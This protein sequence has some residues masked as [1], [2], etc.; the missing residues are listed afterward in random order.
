VCLF[1]QIIIVNQATRALFKSENLYFLFDPHSN[2]ID[3][4]A[5]ICRANSIEKI[6]DLL[7][8]LIGNSYLETFFDMDFMQIN[9]IKNFDSKLIDTPESTDS[10][11]LD[12]FYKELY[13]SQFP[14]D[15]DSDATIIDLSYQS[16]SD[17][18]YNKYS[19]FS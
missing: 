13:P 9:S 12:S 19:Q 6:D 1:L 2:N 15:S 14:E 7:I 11:I 17:F 18:D 5:I 4:N 3:R 16:D 10:T 8:F